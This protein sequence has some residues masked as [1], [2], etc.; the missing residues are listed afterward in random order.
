MTSKAQA[1]QAYENLARNWLCDERG[2]YDAE[3]PD[4]IPT[5]E[6]KDSNYKD[7]RV[8]QDYY[9][10]E[11]EPVTLCGLN[12]D[13]V[14]KFKNSYLSLYE[15]VF[16]GG[17]SCAAPDGFTSRLQCCLECHTWY[18]I[19]D[20]GHDD[21]DESE[22]YTCKECYKEFYYT[23]EEHNEN[24]FTTED[25]ASEEDAQEYFDTL[26]NIRKE[27]LKV[28]KDNSKD[29]ETIDCNDPEEEDEEG[30]AEIDIYD[31]CKSCRCPIVSLS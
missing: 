9:N 29:D 19:D 13:Q 3:D 22:G 27:L 4:E 28:Y 15:L 26:G 8:L 5:V 20:M 6:L 10:E 17:T 25:F 21:D 31:S 12:E 16:V 2:N 1:K 14:Q 18:D 7:L 30:G 24:G 11:D 23:V